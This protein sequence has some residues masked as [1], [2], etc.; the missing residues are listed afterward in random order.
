MALDE[1]I[2][3]KA[4]FN[5]EIMRLKRFLEEDGTE[6]TPKQSRNSCRPQ[7]S[8]SQCLGWAGIPK[9]VTSQTIVFSQSEQ[10][11][12]YINENK[13]EAGSDPGLVSVSFQ[14]CDGSP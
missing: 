6:K 10:T 14:V 3:L 1:P 4:F 2:F 5:L 9:T 11:E 7:R 13:V 8:F 12:V